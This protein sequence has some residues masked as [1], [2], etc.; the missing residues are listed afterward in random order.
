M[1]A[2]PA[3]PSMARNKRDAIYRILAQMK[4]DG[5]NISDLEACR[6]HGASSTTSDMEDACSAQSDSSPSLLASPVSLDD[7]PLP[8]GQSL[9]KR[10]RKRT[11]ATMDSDD[12]TGSVQSTSVQLKA[13]RSLA[14]DF[15]SHSP[16]DEVLG[17]Q[18]EGKDDENDSEGPSTA[19]VPLSTAAEDVQAS[20]ASS[21]SI[22]MDEVELVDTFM[23]L[24]FPSD[25]LAASAKRSRYRFDVRQAIQ[26]QV[27]K[28]QSART[29]GRWRRDIDPSPN[30]D[31]PEIIAGGVTQNGKTLIKVLAI[32]VGHLLGVSSI[33]VSTTRSG[34]SSLSNKIERYLLRDLHP[35]LQ[36]TIK[37]ICELDARKHGPEPMCNFLRKHGCLFINDTA[38]QLYNASHT[39]QSARSCA[40]LGEDFPCQLILDE[41]DSYY[42]NSSDPIQLEKA[43]ADLHQQVKPVLR[44]S[45]SA[46]LI[47]VFLHLKDKK[48]GLDSDSIIYTQP[49][50]TYVGVRDFKPLQ[51]DGKNQ[52]LMPKDL[53]PANLYSNHLTDEVIRQAV[54]K[55]C[56]LTLV[57]TNPRVDAAN[58]VFE[59][60]RRIQ[61]SYPRVAALI[62]V[63]RGRFYMPPPQ[64]R[65]PEDSI[66][67]PPAY[68][69][70]RMDVSALI[71][72][73][74]GHV[75][76]ETPLVV[77]GYSQMIR[78]DT[79]RSNR[80][81]P[82]HIICALGRAMSIE[83]MV[84][85]M[86]RASY[87][88]SKLED[89][90][91]QHVTVLTYPQ[92]FDSAQAYPQWLAEM[93]QK[94]QEGM[95]ISEATSRLATYSDRANVIFRQ[96]KPIGQRN[97]NLRL[98]TSFEDP[99]PGCERPG[100]K[101]LDRLHA[102][103]PVLQTLRAIAIENRETSETFKQEL[104]D[105]NYKGT[106]MTAKEFADAYN[107][108]IGEG[109]RHVTVQAITC[110][111]G[112]LV[113]NG[114]L[115]RSKGRRVQPTR[116]WIASKE[117]LQPS[118]AYRSSLGSSRLG[119]LS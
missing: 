51:I 12:E 81:V 111:L 105:Y 37:H 69:I 47:P 67:P 91:F 6:S 117:L 76:L 25:D 52:F 86:G 109:S 97:D 5:I 110:K 10:S 75:G 29:G 72:A 87:Q 26:Y 80:R 100:R 32:V 102:E 71:E 31:M 30:G 103:D 18:D 34:T 1:Q 42:R 94:L 107:E 45:V 41:A 89:N 112:K 57:I 38:R 78:G 77:L 114:V 54:D 59:L 70:R 48:F 106:G 68:V 61:N 74:D 65:L 73:I 79:F 21:I 64:P 22:D 62:V 92:D 19:R 108:R 90:G 8:R 101:F 20:L 113:D 46:T 24:I 56:S 16:S 53:K 119:M 44:W 35:K 63:G 11:R 7:S 58:N 115:E 39:I 33:I 66:A 28:L 43:L 36:P 55:P 99:E 98:E 23:R 17:S 96:N 50:H 118:T 40:H 3:T 116:Y 49:D 84:Q 2:P 14:H 83:K 60:A 82:T 9:P 95:G 104:V 85:A 13:R 27:R 88:D 4:Q 15:A 93:Q